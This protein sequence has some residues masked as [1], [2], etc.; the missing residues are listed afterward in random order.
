MLHGVGMDGDNSPSPDISASPSSGIESLKS[1]KCDLD[2]E[3]DYRWV[4]DSI[5]V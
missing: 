4:M 2:I 3:N 5:N 1:F